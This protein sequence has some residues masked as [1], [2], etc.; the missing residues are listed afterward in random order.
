[1]KP[2][3]LGSIAA[4][5]G[6]ATA[7][8]AALAAEPIQ[9]VTLNVPVDIS[10]PQVDVAQA[11]ADGAPQLTCNLY[12]GRVGNPIALPMLK[13]LASEAQPLLV[14]ASGKFS[15]TVAMKF[16]VPAGQVQAGWTYWCYLSR[17]NSKN[18]CE[19][20]G[21]AKSRGLTVGTDNCQ[22]FQAETK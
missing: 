2:R 8:S 1:M 7:V 5:V 11:F 10:W 3:L 9:A 13:P 16:S 22:Q 12:S 15:Q 6:F 20:S 17:H 4:A 19:L 21:Y 18:Y 14:D